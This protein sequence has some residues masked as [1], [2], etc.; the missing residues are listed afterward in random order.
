MHQQ[1]ER[2]T[3]SLKSEGSESRLN[4]AWAMQP[5]S[6]PPSAPVDKAARINLQVRR[7][8]RR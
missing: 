1:K 5:A 2:S 8:W 3:I 6:A 4:T 7:G